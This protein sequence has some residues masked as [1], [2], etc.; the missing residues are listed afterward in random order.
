MTS[1]A[2]GSVKYRESTCTRR[3]W[4]N[5]K[6]YS[7]SA[8]GQG[9]V[10]QRWSVYLRTQT[11]NN[12]KLVKLLQEKGPAYFEKHFTFTLLEFFGKNYDKDKIIARE[13]YWKMCFNTIENGYNAN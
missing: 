7:G 3:H 8:Y 10:A 2:S 11:G 6:L 4:C 12:K 5:G 9:G 1:C 13:Q